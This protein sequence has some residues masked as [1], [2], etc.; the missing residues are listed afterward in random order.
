LNV[1]LS[2]AGEIGEAFEQHG[3]GVER[4]PLGFGGQI[5]YGKFVARRPVRL[6][7]MPQ[8]A[9]VRTLGGHELSIQLIVAI[10]LIA[11]N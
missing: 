9:H 11:K 8:I 6:C 1:E 5:A 3:K 7:D 4:I 10:K 2:T